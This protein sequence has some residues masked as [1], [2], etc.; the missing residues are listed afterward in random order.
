MQRFIQIMTIAMAFVGIIVGAG[1]ASGQEVLQYFVAFGIDGLWGA[2]L[3]GVV[4]TLMA[5]VILQLGSYF[6]ANEHG[7]VFKRVAHPVFA[8]I[9]DIGVVVTLFSTGVVMIAGAGSNMQQQWDLP[10]WVGAVLMLVLV[11]AAGMLDVEK[12]TALIGGI[13][14]FILLFIII[15]SV[16][17][18]LTADIDVARLD[19]AAL[20]IVD[21]TLPHW[22]VAAVNYVGFN[23]MVAVSM[24]I[25]IGGAMFNP[26]WAGRGGMLGGLIYSGMLLISALTLFAAVE[27]VGADDLPML[28]I[29]NRLHPILG[30]L[31]AV[32]IYAMIFNTAIGMFYPLGKRLTAAN[33]E[34]F[35]MVFIIVTGIGF[36]LSFIGFSTLIAWV[37]P[38]LGYIG[39]LLITVMIWVWARNRGRI[40]AEATRRDLMHRLLRHRD[41]GN[42]TGQEQADYNRAV[43]ESNL[44][45]ED[46]ERAHREETTG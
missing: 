13:T 7:E 1:F 4:M 25:V 16:Y 44:P 40:S 3:S 38:V 6:R 33:P 30:Q 10:V 20:E 17:T 18:V 21:T 23:L 35:R 14:P 34:R 22:A 41:Q 9:L 26:R 36:G 24:A 32:V 27:T 39:V 46:I 29:I 45:A 15:A 43:A 28:T 31:M 2:L 8:R 5:V 19:T 42:F 37:Y 11:L 12:V